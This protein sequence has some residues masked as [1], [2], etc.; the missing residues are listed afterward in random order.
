MPIDKYKS[1]MREARENI[2]EEVC[3]FIE[4]PSAAWQLAIN[5]LFD[6]FPKV[7]KSTMFFSWLESTLVNSPTPLAFNNK[8]L[9]QV[10]SLVELVLIKGIE[11]KL[12]LKKIGVVSKP[13]C[14]S[15]INP[16]PDNILCKLSQKEI[17]LG[18]SSLQ[19]YLDL[20]ACLNVLP[21][22]HQRKQCYTSQLDEIQSGVYI[23]KYFDIKI[24]KI[25]LK[26]E[27]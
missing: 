23:P 16:L 5:T 27:E 6:Q 1:L 24:D 22:L 4:C 12:F 13:Y 25:E 21:N 26:E 3:G 7:N 17:D 10:L 8:N 18:L 19:T 2:I 15:H 11:S 20:L 14:L 9:E